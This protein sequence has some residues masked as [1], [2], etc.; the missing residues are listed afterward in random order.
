MNLYGFR[1]KATNY[2]PNSKFI[3]AYNNDVTTVKFDTSYK[4]HVGN[5]SILLRV[6]GIEKLHCMQ[7][8]R[9]F[10]DDVLLLFLL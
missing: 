2:Q 9:V 5:Q 1:N 4:L 3:C 6:F 8:S 10:I 7:S